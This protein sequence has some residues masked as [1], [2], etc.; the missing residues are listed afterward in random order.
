M[1]CN[2]EACLHSGP[3]WSPIPNFLV[4]VTEMSV[5][6]TKC[7]LRP[8]DGDNTRQGEPGGGTDNSRHFTQNLV[9]PSECGAV[10]GRP[11]APVSPVLTII[12]V[13]TTRA[14]CCLGPA[15]VGGQTNWVLII[16]T[17]FLTNLINAASKLNTKKFC[18]YLIYLWTQIC[19]RSQSGS[20]FSRKQNITSLWHLSLFQ[21]FFVIR[22]WNC[23]GV[24]R[25]DC[26]MIVVTKR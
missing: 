17:V 7:W 12:Q 24:T 2:A 1:H 16:D 9:K 6:R 25:F 14:N 18:A 5:V 8:I 11:C 23:Y 13:F 22:V 15:P 3:G 19:S 20:N 4:P 26:L 10:Q 21:A